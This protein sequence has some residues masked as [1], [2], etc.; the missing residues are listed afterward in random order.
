MI[1]ILALF[2]VSSTGST[3]FNKEKNNQ[4]KIFADLKKG[5]K[6]VSGLRPTKG[7]TVLVS[8]KAQ[9]YTHAVTEALN[10]LK[11]EFVQVETLQA[12]AAVAD[13]ERMIICRSDLSAEEMNSVL[14]D[15][16]DKGVSVILATL[17]NK[18][19]LESE[20][21]KTLL[22]IRNIREWDI[23]MDGIRILESFMLGE[24]MD[25]EEMPLSKVPYKYQVSQNLISMVF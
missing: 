1:L 8:D 25:Y 19:V 2:Q 21:L 14:K 4:I 10:M 15:C 7:K 20:E 9:T 17:P 13:M 22:G 12:A 6:S 24:R 5:D 23:K 11:Y 18:E 16:L 3:F